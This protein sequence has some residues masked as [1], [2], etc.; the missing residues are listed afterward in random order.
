MAR[1]IDL[2][3][4]VFGAALAGALLIAF[5]FRWAGW[6][7][8]IDDSYITL[9]NALTIDGSFVSPFSGSSPFNGATSPVHLLLVAGLAKIF[10]AALAISLA[11]FFGAV[12]F[13]AA[14]AALA[15]R[16]SLSGWRAYA[17]IVI[18]LCA[19]LTSYQ[20]TNG[21]ETSLALAGF[22]WA[23]YL[24]T[25]EGWK[26]KVAL[27]ILLGT[28]PFVRPELAVLP[29]LVF[30]SLCWQAIISRER[31]FSDALKFLALTA[32]AALPWLALLF[33]NTGSIIPDSINTKKYFFSEG[34]LPAL[35]K[36]KGIKRALL[37]FLPPLGLLL[38]TIPWLLR[39]L[40]GRVLA[41]F[42]AAFLAAYFVSFPGAL[43]HY[44]GRYLYL[45]LPVFLFG[46]CEFL[47]PG[48]R[49]P[50]LAGD[51]LLVLLTLQIAFLNLPKS[52]S[53]SAE[54]RGF[55]AEK[56]F[57]LGEW[58]NANVP[59]G[60]KVLIHDSGYLGYVSK[61][62]LVDLVGLKTVSSARVHEEKTWGTCGAG[63]MDAIAEIT[64]RQ[65]PGYAVVFQD[66][67]KIFRISAGITKA[68]GLLEPLYSQPG[69]YTVYKLNLVGGDKR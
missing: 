29:V 58:I 11:S 46:L 26:H 59:P 8:P 23:I 15:S 33:F 55:T 39:S 51:V 56:L 14:I 35:I 57:P 47:R 4:T 67:E 3:L 64:A 49:A 12:L 32:L 52:L 5:N 54:R 20:L 68:G 17:F 45:L 50:K 63:R 9:Q 31:S 65:R 42:C 44:D 27:P 6:L 48:S 34:C 28:L 24:W 40:Q 1:N 10:D 69:G 19:G 38:L 30:A 43:I 41:L 21:L 13:A 16:G 2:K 61:R 7:L 53:L 18:A 36:L 37:N 22:S 25:G 62:E 66:W 60:E